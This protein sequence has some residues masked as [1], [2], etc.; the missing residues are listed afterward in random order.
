MATQYGIKFSVHLITNHFGNL[1]AKVCECLLRRGP[2]TFEQL[3]RFTE[4][5]K[6][7]VKNSLLV[8]VQNNCVQAFILE[9]EGR[10]GSK[11]NT[12]YLAL[13]DSIL[14]RLRFP[15]FLEIVSQ[16]LDEECVELLEGL[17]RD[18]RL[19]LKQMVDRAS[20]RKENAVPLDVVQ[21]SL[22][23]LSMLRY[24][25]RCPS[26]E[27]VISPP[28]EQDTKKR[29]AKSKIA[30]ESEMIEY[31]VL[32]AAVPAEGIR[33]SLTANSE[34]INNS[35]ISP[36]RGVGENVAKE[37]STLFRANFEEFVRRRR[38]KV[39]VENIRTAHDDG[40]A[41]VLGAV[42]D[43]T[44]NAEKKVKMEKSVPLTLDAIFSEVQ[45][46]EN[47][48][49]M[50]M[51]RVRSSLVLLGCTQRTF[52]GPYSIELNKIIESARDEEVESI[53]LKRYG[54][55]AYRMFRLLSKTGRLLETDK[56]AE[57]T[58]VEKRDTPKIL[59]KL[60]KDDYLHMEKLVLT[61][62][63]QSKFLLWKVNKPILWEHVLDEMYHAA[64]NLSLRLAYEQEKDG[65]LLAVPKDRIV[66]QLQKRYKRLRNSWL[67]LESS[68]MKLDDTLM[69]FHDF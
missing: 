51:E 64:L 47:G 35:D 24:A 1:V 42:L 21:E 67:L 29:G 36:R 20:Q 30:E 15:K 62:A 48:R 22:H 17:L 18:G 14:H 34:L 56:I 8:L 52:D 3:G 26:P 16:D 69:L 12:Q 43:A 45:K 66:G 11:V 54:T 2:L 19:T 7:Q 68:L 65:E 28:V 58:F 6:E 40:A 53:V 44:R 61:G 10:E 5:T 55:D 39:L 25:E 38:H 57:S 60:W 49:A 23:K 4:L 50:T 63:R 27:P 31:R 59:Y 37:D 33:F 13:F 9:Q 46:T 32:E 41:I